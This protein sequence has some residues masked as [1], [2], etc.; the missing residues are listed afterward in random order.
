MGRPLRRARSVDELTE[1]LSFDDP[2]C[3]LLGDDAA[4][5]EELAALIGEI[6]SR[7]PR[8]I[9]ILVRKTLDNQLFW[10]LQETGVHGTAQAA[11]DVPKIIRLIRRHLS[12]TTGRDPNEAWKDLVSGSW[13]ELASWRAAK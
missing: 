8:T 11:H 1:L 13:E 5:L 10:M 12:R 6:R 9:V 4:P 2:Q 7:Y 3:L